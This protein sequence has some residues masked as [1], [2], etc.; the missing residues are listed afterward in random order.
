M[1]VPF[2]SFVRFCRNENKY[3]NDYI[4]HLDEIAEEIG[5][6][7]LQ[8][9]RPNDKVFWQGN[10]HVSRSKKNAEKWKSLFDED[11]EPFIPEEVSEDELMDTMTKNLP[12]PGEQAK[13]DMVYVIGVRDTETVILWNIF[14]KTVE[15]YKRNPDEPPHFDIP[16]HDLKYMFQVP[17]GADTANIAACCYVYHEGPWSSLISNMH[18]LY[19][20]DGDA[21]SVVFKKKGAVKPDWLKEKEKLKQSQ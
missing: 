17:W 21:Y 1:A 4:V 5:W 8:V 3:L 19:L 18:A 7:N 13:D 16:A 14:K 20:P 15:L 2:A 6:E 12:D 11:F 9:L 10:F